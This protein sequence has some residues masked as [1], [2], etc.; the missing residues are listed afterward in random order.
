MLIFGSLY[1]FVTEA[2]EVINYEDITLGQGLLF[3][4]V[5]KLKLDITQDLRNLTFTFKWNGKAVD[6]ID[7]EFVNFK[8]ESE[9]KYS[10][11]NRKYQQLK[12]EDISSSNNSHMA[13]TYAPNV[14]SKKWGT[15]Y[16]VDSTSN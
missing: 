6:M 1:L 3:H 10:S 2:I 4:D 16:R 13:L 11:S 7:N 12:F 5:K 8:G 9:I 15:I 14:L